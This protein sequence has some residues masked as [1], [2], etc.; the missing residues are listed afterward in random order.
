MQYEF[1]SETFLVFGYANIIKNRIDF[2]HIRLI[3]QIV[4]TTGNR[5]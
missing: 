5:N 4:E 1:K 3:N 2:D